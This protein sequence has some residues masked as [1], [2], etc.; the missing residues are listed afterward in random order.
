MRSSSAEGSLEFVPS[1]NTEPDSDSESMHIASAWRDEAKGMDVRA[2]AVLVGPGVNTQLLWHTTCEAGSL[3]VQARESSLPP[4]GKA[5]RGLVG[6]KVLHSA[7]AHCT[8]SDGILPSEEGSYN[9]NHTNG[10]Q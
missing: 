2:H 3:H 10:M 7:I 8:G 5:L 6:S 9:R 4:A 1:E